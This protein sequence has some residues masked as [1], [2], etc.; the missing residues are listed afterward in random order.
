MSSVVGK[1]LLHESLE[2]RERRIPLG[3]DAVEVG[4]RI[5]EPPGLE[6]PHLVP[7]SPRAA[8]ETRVRKHAEM[9]GDRLTRDRGLRAQLRDRAGPA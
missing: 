1:S 5:H 4:V 9:L 6:V 2:A 7:S 8:D 3:R